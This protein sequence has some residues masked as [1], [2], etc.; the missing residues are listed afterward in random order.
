MWKRFF[1][2]R[3]YIQGLLPVPLDNQITDVYRF[4]VSYF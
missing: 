4:L 3:F 1:P 2:F